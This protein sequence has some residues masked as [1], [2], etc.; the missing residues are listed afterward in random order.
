MKISQQDL[1]RAEFYGINLDYFKQLILV[2][3]ATPA[4]IFTD[5]REGKRLRFTRINLI[6]KDSKKYTLIM[7]R[8]GD[9]EPHQARIMLKLWYYDQT[10]GLKGWETTTVYDRS[11]DDWHYAHLLYKKIMSLCTELT[12]G[13]SQ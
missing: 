4:Q 12:K 5:A 11:F 2:G 6:I 8:T 10:G 1:Y 9:Q 7:K 3:H 13:D